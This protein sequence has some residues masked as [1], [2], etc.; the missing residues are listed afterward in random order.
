MYEVHISIN[1]IPLETNNKEP[2]KTNQIVS[3]YFFIN[4]E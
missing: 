2:I 4:Q 1:K 3:T